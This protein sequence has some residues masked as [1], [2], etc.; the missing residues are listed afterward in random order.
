MNMDIRAELKQLKREYLEAERDYSDEKKCLLKVIN[1]FG[2]VVAMHSELEEELGAVKKMVNAEK[3]LPLNLIEKEIG[4]LRGKIFSKEI[5][6]GSDGGAKELKERLLGSCRVIKKVMA[7]LLDDFYPITGDL[8]EKADSIDV[9]CHEEMA[10]S[11]LQEA[12]GAFLSFIMRLKEKIYEDFRYISR[13]FLMFLDQ[14]KGLEKTLTNEFGSDVRLKKIEYFEMEVNGEVGSIVD[15]FNIHDT[16]SEIKNTV[17]EKITNIKRLV[18]K[19]KEEELRADKNAQK[20]INELKNKIHEAEKNAIKLS[21]KAERFQLAAKKD[22]LTG[23]YNRH[24]F[25]T[26]VMEAQ[27]S[28]D[29][30]R[31]PLSVVLFDVDEFKWIND[32]FG[33]VAGDKVLKKVAQSLKKTFRKDDFIARYGGDE[34]AVVIEGITEEMVNERI[35]EFKGNFK[36]KRFISHKDGDITVRV[37]AGIALAVVGET[38]EDLINRADMA[39]YASKK[40]KNRN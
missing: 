7:A 36:K 28:F 18:A 15:S 40:E 30:G 35:L 19:K 6:K 21:Q 38:P 8:K 10:Q 31:E 12:S 14:V 16:I 22:G 13:T 9:D 4:K 17:I 32:T 39:M 27:K 1:T 34:F 25:D 24:A 29:E 20:N 5:E 33:H 37:S 2:S 23:L 11:D 26:K 3:E